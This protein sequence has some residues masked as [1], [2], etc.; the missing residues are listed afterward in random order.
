MAALTCI[1]VRFV[2]GSSAV[3]SSGAKNSITLTTTDGRDINLQD[4]ANTGHATATASF[5]GTTLT[6]GT[7]VSAVKTGTVALTS[8][9]GAIATANASAQVF[10]TAGVNN[11]SFSSVAAL[12]IST[13]TGAS[14]ALSVLDAALQQVNSSRAD[15]GAIQNRFS[16]TISNLNTTS[17]NLAASQSRI[18]D[19]DFAAETANLSRAQILQQA[20]TA[21]LA[22]AN[23]LPQN[24]LS[25]LQ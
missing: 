20:G 3:T 23:A 18:R 19:A 12:D 15:L 6:E 13:A 7:T 25:L 10:G 16:T 2:A 14:N 17:E 4:Y 24:V 11:S 1:A 8:S 22:Q 5:D 21:M 9:K